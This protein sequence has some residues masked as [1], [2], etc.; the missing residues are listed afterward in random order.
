MNPPANS[1]EGAI[2]T[3]DSWILG[4]LEARDGR[5]VSLRGERVPR[6]STPP[7]PWILPGFIDGHVHGGD[8]A[9]VMEGEASVRRMARFHLTR[10]VTSLLATTMTAS[11]ADIRAALAG[12]EAVRQA[13]AAGEATVLGTHLEGPFLSPAKLGAQPP[14]MLE[15]DVALALELHRIS[16]LSVATLAPELAGALPLIKALQ[17]LGV[18]A[19]LGHTCASAACV[20]RAMNAGATGFTH[21]FNAMS[22]AEHRGTG[23]AGAA[24]AHAEWAE[25]LCDGEHVEATMIHAARRAIPGLYAV[26]DATSAAGMPDGPFQLGDVAIEKVGAKVTLRGTETLAGSAHALDDALRHLLGIGVPLGE[27]SDMLSTRAAR[28][29]GHA[30]L[31]TLVEG[32]P[33]DLVEWSPEHRITQVFQAGVRVHVAAGT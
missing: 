1:L 17:G 12:I 10:G 33:A 5:I 23:C 18:R 28:Y 25:I 19:Q 9:D 20:E 30:P 8:G 15:P 27:A 26:S 31:G 11:V 2:L 3:P 13:S 29:L 14:A 21:L 7:G 4:Q 22:G 24:L 6:D 32:A 16:P